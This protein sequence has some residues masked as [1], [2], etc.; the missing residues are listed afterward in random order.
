MYNDCC[1]SEGRYSSLDDWDIEQLSQ[2]LIVATRRAIFD[3][4][5]STQPDILDAL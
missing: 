5:I 2:H 3:A 1:W 4:P